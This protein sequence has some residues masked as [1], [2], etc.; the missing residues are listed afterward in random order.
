VI[1]GRSGKRGC[2]PVAGIAGRRGRNVGRG[3]ARGSRAVVASRACAGSNAGMTESR[4]CPGAGLV[5]GVAR[6]SRG[7][8]RG[9]LAG[10]SRAI[11]ASCARAR[12][13]THVT[14]SRRCQALVRWQVSQD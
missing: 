4:R 13:N 3:F 6:L 5:T 8:M 10:R 1:H 11:V 12:C 7:N 14:E 2:R 9:R